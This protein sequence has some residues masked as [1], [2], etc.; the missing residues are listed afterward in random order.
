MKFFFPIT[1]VAS[2]KEEE[3][4]NAYFEEWKDILMGHTKPTHIEP[5]C[6]QLDSPDV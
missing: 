5:A 6:H 3:N 2:F 1:C 4:V